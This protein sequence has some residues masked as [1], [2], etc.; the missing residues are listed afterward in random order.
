MQDYTNHEPKLRYNFLSVAESYSIRISSAFI[1][2]GIDNCVRFCQ[3]ALQSVPIQSSQPF[4]TISLNPTVNFKSSHLHLTLSVG[5]FLQAWL[6]KAV[7]VNY[8]FVRCAKYK[9]KYR[10]W[11]NNKKNITAD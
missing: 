5:L 4:T 9:R 7:E 11:F 6:I 10:S 1:K 8:Q 3:N 2:P